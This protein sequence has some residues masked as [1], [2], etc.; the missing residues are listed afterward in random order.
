[1]QR[2]MHM[3]YFLFAFSSSE[4]DN[5]HAL[6]IPEQSEEKHQQVEGGVPLHK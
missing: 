1:M 5:L 6:Q 3:S 4:E 2:D